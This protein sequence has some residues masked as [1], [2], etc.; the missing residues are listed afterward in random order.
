MS[1]RS[2]FFAWYK[3]KDYLNPQKVSIV[4]TKIYDKDPNTCSIEV[5][6]LMVLEHPKY[7]LNFI[8]ETSGFA[9]E[10]VISKNNKKLLRYG[11][12]LSINNEVEQFGPPKLVSRNKI[13]FVIG[14]I[15]SAILYYFTDPVNNGYFAYQYYSQ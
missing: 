1:R 13:L 5:G 11:Q 2:Y 7:W 14:V 6:T 3:P 8:P 12:T 15:L 9:T 10:M 4:K